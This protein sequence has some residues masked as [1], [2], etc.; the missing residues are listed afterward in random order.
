MTY[1]SSQDRPKPFN[2]KLTKISRSINVKEK[3]NFNYL[4]KHEVENL[5]SARKVNSEKL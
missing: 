3:I 5:V 1:K 4:N 2:C